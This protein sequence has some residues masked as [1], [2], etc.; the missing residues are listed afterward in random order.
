MHT[1][2]SKGQS[3]TGL[4]HTEQSKGQSGDRA[5]AYVERA[6]GTKA[7]APTCRH[8]WPARELAQLRPPTPAPLV[9]PAPSPA[10]DA[11]DASS[12]VAP[13]TAPV[14]KPAPLQL[15][16][17]PPSTCE[18]GHQAPT[19]HLAA[20]GVGGWSTNKASACLAATAVSSSD[21]RPPKKQQAR[22]ATKG[23]LTTFS[24]VGP[25]AAHLD[26]LEQGGHK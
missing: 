22:K 26:E 5:D 13:G 21:S 17:C 19:W 25:H 24:S 16:A 14:E 2:Q 18:Q 11:A 1:E 23:L 8:S 12:S 6:Q 3:G 20:R 7:S 10:P 4:M 9:A 15:P